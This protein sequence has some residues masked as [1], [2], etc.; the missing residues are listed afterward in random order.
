MDLTLNAGVNHAFRA[1]TVWAGHPWCCTKQS[2]N[3]WTLS[4]YL[5]ALG[6]QVYTV[7]V[8]QCRLVLGSRLHREARHFF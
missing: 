5:A 3:Q 7:K 2:T 1:T 6:P 4:V 8:I